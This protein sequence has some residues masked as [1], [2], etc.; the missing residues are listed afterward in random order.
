MKSIKN[1]FAALSFL[2]LAPTPASAADVRGSGWLAWLAPAGALIGLPCALCAWLLCLSLKLLADAPPFL[3]A[4]AGG[5]VWLCCEIVLSRGLHWDGVADIGDGCGA[6]DGEKF[7]R[8]VKDSR[9]GA[10]GALALLALALGETIFASLLFYRAL[11][12]SS[13]F[14]P[15]AL[16]PALAVA[17]SRLA[18]IW[19]GSLAPPWRGSSLGKLVCDASDAKIKLIS[20]LWGCA[21]L[22]AA[23]AAG[24]G[25]PAVAALLFS[26]ILALA[27]LARRARS[28]GGLSGDFFGAAIEGCQILFLFFASFP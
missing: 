26:Q 27:L 12:T 16:L 13:F 6:G 9:L 2:S 7:W 23:V 25:V 5:W 22:L 28:L 3:A 8:A 11:A 4:L 20:T 17:W 14:P 19:L 18:P 1:L 10:F 24:M 21:V 15:T